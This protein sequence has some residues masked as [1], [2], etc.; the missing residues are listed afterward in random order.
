M[1]HFPATCSFEVENQAVVHLELDMQKRQCVGHYPAT[2]CHIGDK[3]AIIYWELN[4][5]TEYLSGPF[6][7]SI[8][9]PIV[10]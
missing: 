2:A 6:P 3:Q 8:Y 10:R 7:S 1:G 5:E 9:L 4:I